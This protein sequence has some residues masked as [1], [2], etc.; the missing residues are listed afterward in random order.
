VFVYLCVHEG[1]LLGRLNRLEHL[2]RG[3]LLDV[4]KTSVVQR[5]E[6]AATPAGTA[7]AYKTMQKRDRATGRPAP[8]PPYFHGSQSYHDQLTAT[9]KPPWHAA[10]RT[11]LVIEASLSGVTAP[12]S[13]SRRSLLFWIR[14][15]R[16]LRTHVL[17]LVSVFLYRSKMAAHGQHMFICNEPEQLNPIAGAVSAFLYSQR[18]GIARNASPQRPHIPSTHRSRSLQPPCP[19]LVLR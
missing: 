15:D 6:S 1:L 17:Y 12:T 13:T 2:A 8:C 3:H 19:A 11:W 5:A 9:G 4:I 7:R 18:P 14:L 16:R 10:R